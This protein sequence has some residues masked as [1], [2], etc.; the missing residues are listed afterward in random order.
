MRK[1]SVIILVCLVILVE[2]AK[3]QR[4]QLWPST[5][6]L[7]PSDIEDEN[8]KQQFVQV[9]EWADKLQEMLDD[10]F[11]KIVDIPFN[12]SESLIVANTGNANTEFSVDHNLNRTPTGFILTKS[13][14]ACSIY[15]SGT[16]W[17]TSTIYLKCNVAN[18]AITITVF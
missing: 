2:G 16:S 6:R 8:I 13:D 1:F 10:T 18:A 4:T 9:K 11:R 17:T 5:A 14:K 12:R 15:D 7:T 3:L